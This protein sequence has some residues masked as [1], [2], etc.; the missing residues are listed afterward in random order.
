[1]SCCGDIPEIVPDQS[2]FNTHECIYPAGFC[3][4]GVYA[5]LTQPQDKCLYTRKIT[6]RGDKPEVLTTGRGGAS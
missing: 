4:T 2:S 5:S 3:S 6:H 1:M